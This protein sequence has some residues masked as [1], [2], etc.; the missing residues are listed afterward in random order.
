M[1]EYTAKHL[2]AI[3][4]AQHPEVEEVAAAAAQPVH[5]SRCVVPRHVHIVT[6]ENSADDVLSLVQAVQQQ[7]KGPKKRTLTTKD[8]SQLYNVP[9][10]TLAEW[11]RNSKGP[12]WNKPGKSVLYRVED[13]EAY[14]DAQRV[15]TLA[16]DRCA[17]PSR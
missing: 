15:R 9:A 13:V 17:R 3:L 2:R 10:G 4:D 7:Q 5:R 12:A 14:F 16:S 8:V 1:T 11:R 6:Y